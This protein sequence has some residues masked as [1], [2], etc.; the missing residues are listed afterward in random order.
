MD[1]I[2]HHTF[3]VFDHEISLASVAAFVIAVAVGV[4]LSN[5]IQSERVRRSASK[6]GL[7]KNVVN[8]LTSI[9]GLVVLVSCAIAGLNLAG[10]PINWNGEIPG[11]RISISKLLWMVAMVVFV[12]WLSST[13]KRVLFNRYLS[14]M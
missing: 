6:L 3:R 10:I 14:R 12:F 9:V 1:W 5:V 11:T 2:N 4:F 7:E 8:F 13:T